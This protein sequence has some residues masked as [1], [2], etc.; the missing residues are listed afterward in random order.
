MGSRQAHALD[1][2]MVLRVVCTNVFGSAVQCHM[3]CT[4]YNTAKHNNPLKSALTKT[5][6]VYGIGNVRNANAQIY[7]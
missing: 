4:V 3:W 7:K 6:M 5:S 2:D 1:T